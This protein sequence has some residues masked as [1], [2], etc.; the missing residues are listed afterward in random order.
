MR[1]FVLWE[2]RNPPVP[3]PIMVQ[4][5]RGLVARGHLVELARCDLLAVPVDRL[6][7][8]HDLY[9][10]KSHTPFALAVAA[11]L[12][13]QGA[14][15]VNPYPACAVT[16]DKARTARLLE[17]GGI[18]VPRTWAVGDLAAVR[19]LL[20]SAP[21]VLKPAR[22]LHGAGV[23]IVRRPGD[24]D[25]LPALAEP[26][27]VQELV[28]G[29][30]VDLKLYV[31]GDEVFA[32]RKAFAPDSYARP[33][34]AVRIDDETRRLALRV[35]KVT[36]LG[37]YGLDVIESPD[38]PFVV[39]V[40]YFPGYRGHAGAGAAA[41]RFLDDVATGRRELAAPAAA[42]AVAPERLHGQDAA[43]WLA[44]AEGVAR[45]FTDDRPAVL[46]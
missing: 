28:P 22:G 41:A 10:L 33:G 45:M 2:R 16:A 26:A 34:D 24:L 44:Q 19:S 8:A 1:I 40:N 9:V 21:L 35:G 30:G 14:R 12:H 13:L 31:A 18:P 6:V 37:L 39:D 3:S 46:R 32:T 42:P 38:G 17:A 27:V 11:S 23:R 29:T 15:W 25:H 36:G 4:A 20:G 7:P 43:G 5:V